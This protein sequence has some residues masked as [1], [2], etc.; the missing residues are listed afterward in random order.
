MIGS[1]ASSRERLVGMFRNSA[2]VRHFDVTSKCYMHCVSTYVAVESVTSPCAAD[3]FVR[4]A[5]ET[6]SKT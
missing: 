4:V 3:G 2:R 6:L 5:V 1:L